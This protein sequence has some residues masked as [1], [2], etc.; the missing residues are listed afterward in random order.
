M[1]EQNGGKTKNRGRKNNKRTVK[2]AS[3]YGDA[4]RKYMKMY[5]GQ[6]ASTSTSSTAALPPPPPPSDK[7][8]PDNNKENKSLFDKVA[9][10]FTSNS[11]PKDN[12]EATSS[13]ET[14][15]SDQMKINLV[16]LTAL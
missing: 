16:C 5:G 6:A 14:A 8:E 10:L 2:A 12:P 11:D 3:T 1:P 13:S 15:K 4:Y 9:L 7:E